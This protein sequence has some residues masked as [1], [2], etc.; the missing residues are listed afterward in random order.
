MNPSSASGNASNFATR[1]AFSRVGDRMPSHAT[2]RS[3]SNSTGPSGPSATTP[4]MRPPSP[5]RTSS[6]TV[7]S[8][9]IGRS[10]CNASMRAPKRTATATGGWSGRGAIGRPAAFTSSYT[11]TSSRGS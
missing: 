11:P 1:P 7:C 10:R 9:T 3:D 2:T 4:M 8:F 6:V 5:S